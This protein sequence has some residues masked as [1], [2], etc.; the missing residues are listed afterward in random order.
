MPAVTMP[1]ITTTTRIST[2]VKP[3]APA[4]LREARNFAGT[5]LVRDIPVPDVG[6]EAI[7]TGRTVSSQAEEVV[8]LTVAAREDILV[9]VPP[10]VLADALQVA[11]RA[12]V[13]DRRVSWLCRERLQPLLGRRV[14]GIVEPEQGERGLE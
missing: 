10:G 12:P 13:F 6:V 9:V 14:L 2:R 3:R 5:P 7:T 11:A 8:L 4:P 1:M